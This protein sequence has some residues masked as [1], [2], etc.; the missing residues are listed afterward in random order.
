MNFLRRCGKAG[1]YR[2][3]KGGRNAQ[4]IARFGREWTLH[5]TRE[6]GGLHCKLTCK[7][8]GRLLPNSLSQLDTLLRTHVAVDRSVKLCRLERGTGDDSPQLD[9][10][11]KEAAKTAISYGFRSMHNIELQVSD[12]IGSTEIAALLKDLGLQTKEGEKTLE[13]TPQ[14]VSWRDNPDNPKNL[15]LITGGHTR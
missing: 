7:G 14:P 12:D 5:V 10:L 13:P 4:Y 9:I 8:A 15:P 1:G 2:V 11:G 3:H 6:A